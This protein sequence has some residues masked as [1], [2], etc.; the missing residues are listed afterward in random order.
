MSG[1]IETADHIKPW[2]ESLRA[3]GVK[4]EQISGVLRAGE[5]IHAA[6]G[7]GEAYAIRE[8]VSME[9]LLHTPPCPNCWQEMQFT[10][11]QG[12]YLQELALLA[13]EIEADQP[14]EPP[15]PWKLNEIEKYL[16][17]EPKGNLDNEAIRRVFASI[18]EE[19]VSNFQS[20]A[21]KKIE[22][23][24]ENLQKELEV[25]AA[26]LHIGPG[27]GHVIGTGF[28]HPST[29]M[30]Q[31]RIQ[32]ILEEAHNQILQ[33]TRT[34]LVWKP[35]PAKDVRSMLIEHLYKHG[36]KT[37]QLPM[38]FYSD[39]CH[40]EHAI[41]ERKLDPSEVEALETLHSQAAP[42]EPYHLLSEAILAACSV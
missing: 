16:A 38:A 31:E 20:Q 26:Q 12:V 13:G 3:K 27:S 1:V 14:I 37:L 22:E 15:K 8:V 36:K 19:K 6:T 34:L 41:I 33:D 40:H 17:W 39:Y 11:G 42:G 2:L 21:L 29:P 18:I 10:L 23:E 4:I 28:R 32:E 5:K 7:C 35:V 25:R 9:R 30:L 24:K